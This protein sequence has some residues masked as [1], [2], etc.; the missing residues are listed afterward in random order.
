MNI[1]ECRACGAAFWTAAVHQGE[2]VSGAIDG[3]PGCF[4]HAVLDIERF[5]TEKAAA[6]AMNSEF[7]IGNSEMEVSA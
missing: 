3:C 2:P 1:V 7:G 4:G 6:R 5:P